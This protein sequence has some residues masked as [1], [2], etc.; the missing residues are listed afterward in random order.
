MSQPAAR[1]PSCGAPVHFLWAGAV[2]TVCRHCGSVLVRH[3]L[4]LASVGKLSAPPPTVSHVQVGTRGRYGGQGFTV[5][6]R[7]AYAYER[8]GWNEWH[9]VFDD[10]SS[11]W[12][13]DAQAEY[14]VSRLV[15]LPGPLPPAERLQ[16]GQTFRWGQAEYQLTSLTRARY[17]GVEGELPFEYWDKSEVLFADLRG[18]ENRFGTL[19]YSD[20]RP[21]LFLGE[22][23]EFEQLSLTELREPEAAELGG[24]AVRTLACPACGGAVEIRAGELTVNVACGSCGSVLDATTPGLQVLQRFQAAQKV[25]PLI[26]LGARGQWKGAEYAVVGFQVRETEV[27]GERYAWREYLLF[28]PERGFRYLTEYD[29][30]WNDVI[31]LKTLPELGREGKRPVAKLHGETFRHFQSATAKTSFVLGEFPW[32][33]RVGDTAKTD[34]YVAPPRLLSAETADGETTWSLGEYTAGPRLW[35]AFKAPGR[36][37]APKGVY[38]SQPSPHGGSARRFWVVFGVLTALFLVLLVGRLAL[39][40]SQP[41]L[42]ESYAFDPQQ[43][44]S[45]VILTPE[46]TLA[47]RPANLDLTLD[48]DV[49]NG[50]VY[51]DLA[52]IDL[53]SGNATEFGREVSYYFGREDGEDWS[54]GD[55]RDHVR[56]PT[57]PPGRY[58]L[59][60][61]PD[62]PGRVAYRVRLRRDV[63]A[64][65]FY[66]VAFLLLLVPPVFASLRSGTFEARRWA[67]SDYAPESE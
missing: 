4:E 17:L 26:P 57:V 12:L 3:D 30:H 32:Q 37:P 64:T 65:A 51:F 50:G 55:Q 54:E 8:G 11:G 25:E 66:L 14:A 58:T 42:N 62:A 31:P 41:I 1:C 56:I 20:E 16:L 47:G 48:T 13:S 46:F 36:P 2:Q 38:A 49:S 24:S 61:A 29:G 15:P 19:D 6:G 27:E 39:P 45:A 23:V 63:P 7:I 52:L 33:V 5:V 28:H 53:A 60:I 9:L 43:P 59:R 10:D 21:L 44:D 18:R 22:S 40:H 34:D 67:E 35:A